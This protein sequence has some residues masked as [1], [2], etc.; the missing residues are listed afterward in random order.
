[1]LE[2]E[3]WTVR[4]L[5][6]WRCSLVYVAQTL[7]LVLGFGNAIELHYFTR[8]RVTRVAKLWEIIKSSGT[9]YLHTI[10]LKVSYL[11]KITESITSFYLKE[12]FSSVIL[13]MYKS[14]SGMLN[15]SLV[16]HVDL[17]IFLKF[18]MSKPNMKLV[19]YGLRFNRFMSYSN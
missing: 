1:M 16:H 15:Q 8:I 2:D 10:P 6:A 11:F 17:I 7:V 3:E 9:R 5:M 12:F 13:N 14:F 19:G 4:Y 18:S